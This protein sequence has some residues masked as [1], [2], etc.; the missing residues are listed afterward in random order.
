[1]PIGAAGNP[2]TLKVALRKFFTS[3]PIAQ[4]RAKHCTI[5]SVFSLGELAQDSDLAH[6]LGDSNQ[7]EIFSEVKPPLTAY[8][9]KQASKNFNATS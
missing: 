3:A 8:F 2:C 6:C 7:S 5:L 9:N 4:L 1:M